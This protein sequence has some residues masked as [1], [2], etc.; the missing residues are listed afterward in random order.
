MELQTNKGSQGVVFTQGETARVLVK[1]NRSGYFYIQGHILT[2]QKKLSYLLEVNDEKPPH[3][4]ELYVGPEDVNKWID[5]SG[6]GFEI[7]Q[8]F[9]TESLQIFASDT[10]FVKS[11]AIPNTTYRD[12]C[13]VVGGKATEAASLTRGLVRNDQT[14]ERKSEAVLMFQTIAAK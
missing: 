5:I 2:G 6:G 3:A 4:F 8:P 1:L 13:H 7:L 10:S 9:G 14:T 11:G 12:P